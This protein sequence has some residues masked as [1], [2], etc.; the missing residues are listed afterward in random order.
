[1]YFENEV[2]FVSF[3]SLV[4]EKKSSHF[5]SNWDNFNLEENAVSVC[6][7]D[8]YLLSTNYFIKVL[9]VVCE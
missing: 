1:M 3:T 6:A 7:H 9:L 8:V 2:L 5:F 4:H